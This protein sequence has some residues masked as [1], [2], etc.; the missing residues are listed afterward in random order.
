VGAVVT[1]A[2]DGAVGARLASE[3]PFDVILMDLKMPVLDGEG[4]LAAIRTTPGPNDSTPILAFTANAENPAALLRKGFQGVVAKPLNAADMIAVVANAVG[5]ET[6][7]R[8]I[9]RH[10]R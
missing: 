1:E 4:A 5:F 9:A 7:Q 8:E 3:A 2:E 10:G 6:H